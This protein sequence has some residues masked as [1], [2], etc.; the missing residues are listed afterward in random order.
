MRRT[1]MPAVILSGGSRR[2]RSGVEG[3]LSAIVTSAP[4]GTSSRRSYR[5]SKLRP[6]ASPPVIEPKLHGNIPPRVLR[7]QRTERV[8]SLQR[9][10]RRLIQRGNAARLLHSNIFRLARARDLKVDVNPA[11]RVDIGID[12]VLQPVLRNLAPHRVDIPAEAAAE[13]SRASGETQAALG[14]A[15]GETNRTAR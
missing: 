15:R 11:R 4:I 2:L 6:A 14:A 3:P 7:R 8:D 1:T 12:F 9:P 13:I 10:H 5:A